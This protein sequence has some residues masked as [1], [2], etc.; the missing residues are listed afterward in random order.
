MPLPLLFG[1]YDEEHSG[2]DDPAMPVT[3]KGDAPVPGKVEEPSARAGPVNQP[4]DVP[5][6]MKV[7]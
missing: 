4:N 7:T 6:D 1:P 5:E 3:M 2:E